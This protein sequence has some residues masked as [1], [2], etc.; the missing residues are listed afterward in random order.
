MPT[1]WNHQK[2]QEVRLPYYKYDGTWLHTGLNTL[3]GQTFILNSLFLSHAH[4]G[5]VFPLYNIFL[6]NI[7]LFTSAHAGD[8]G[9]GSKDELW[10]PGGKDG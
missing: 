10:G 8:A 9:P 4:Y 2:D 6:A 7:T 3:T 5:C 1:V